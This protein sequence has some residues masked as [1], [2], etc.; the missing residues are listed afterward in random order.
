[1]C[2]KV[3][4][5]EALG[6]YVQVTFPKASALRKYDITPFRS[7]LSDLSL[8]LSIPCSQSRIALPLG[9]SK[10]FSVTEAVTTCLTG[11]G[12]VDMNYTRAFF[13]LVVYLRTLLLK[14]QATY[15]TGRYSLRWI[16][17]LSSCSMTKKW[18]ISLPRLSSACAPIVSSPLTTQYST[19]AATQ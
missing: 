8:R 14:R 4:S 10:R 15:F 18:N 1:M 12:V 2:G 19:L 16:D 6:G 13:S 7:P 17:R 11:G 9:I 3:L 5:L